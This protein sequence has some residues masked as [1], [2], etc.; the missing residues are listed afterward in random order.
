[1]M[2]GVTY[3]DL[4][5]LDGEETRTKKQLKQEFTFQQINYVEA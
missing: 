1:M 4:T 2:P 5:W 3:K